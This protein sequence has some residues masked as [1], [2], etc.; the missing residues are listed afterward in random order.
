MTRG[1]MRQAAVQA[2]GAHL[3]ASLDPATLADDT[4]LSSGGLGLSSVALLQVLIRLEEQFGMTFDDATVARARFTTLGDL[5]S[6]LEAS[7]PGQ[8]QQAP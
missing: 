1:T 6:F 7:L 4:P 2:L 8:Q 5:V 3:H